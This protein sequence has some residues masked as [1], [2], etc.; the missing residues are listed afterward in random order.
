MVRTMRP[1]LDQLVLSLLLGACAHRKPPPKVVPPPPPPVVV[2]PMRLV[3]M[4]LEE[5]KFAELATSVNDRLGHASIKGVT[6]VVQAPISMEMAQL[7]IEC[8]NRS[9]LC[10]GAVAKK[11][12]ADRLLWADIQRD[13]AG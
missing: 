4:P 11:L 10:Y 3:W 8:I 12:N 7:T 1:R 9:P 2:A 13:K 6:E 5:R